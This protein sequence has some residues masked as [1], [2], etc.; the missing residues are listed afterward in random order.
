MRKIVPLVIAAG[1]LLVVGAALAGLAKSTYTYRATMTAGGEIPKPK[2]PAGA[3]GL[4]TA[5]VTETGATR[6]LKWKLTF[7][8]LSGKVIAAHVHRG[9]AGVAGAS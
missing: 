4:F 3:K 1:A 8:G 9:K 7:S 5:T 2:A 6:K